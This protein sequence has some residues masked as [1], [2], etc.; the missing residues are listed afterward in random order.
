M[1]HKPPSV[2]DYAKRKQK[3]NENRRKEYKRKENKNKPITLKI[4]E[5]YLKTSPIYIGA[6]FSDSFKNLIIKKEVFSLVV[7]C[8][9]HWLCLYCTSKTFEIFD[10][11]G[12]LQKKNCSP[13]PFFT[14]LRSHVQGKI[15]YSN[16]QIQSK[17][18]NTCGFY[19]IIFLRMR[20]LGYSYF[21]ILGLFSKNYSKN[22]KLVRKLVNKLK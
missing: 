5:S 3:Q 13:S 6:V 4:I 11:L 2:A 15:L 18:S 22:D 10:P 8:K 14:F 9:S 1:S 16:P 20:E 21:D 7:H 12:F 19:V 17:N